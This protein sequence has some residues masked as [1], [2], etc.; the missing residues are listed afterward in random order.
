MMDL[1]PMRSRKHDGAGIRYMRFREKLGVLL[2]DAN[3]VEIVVYEEVRRHMGVDAAHVYGGMMATLTS[4]CE[5]RNIPYEGTPV[6]TIK[7]FVTGKGNAGK[8]EVIEA[9]KTLGFNPIDDNEADAIALL[10]YKINQMEG[11]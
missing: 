4:E 11:R 8:D 5:R 3:A 9:V 6:Q 10:Y 7:K 1:A 2:S